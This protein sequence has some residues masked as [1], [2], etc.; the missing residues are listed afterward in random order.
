MGVT[1]DQNWVTPKFGG[2]GTEGLKL[3]KFFF[4]I[5]L[6]N[7]SKLYNIFKNQPPRLIRRGDI[8]ISPFFD[9]EKGYSSPISLPNLARKL[10]FGIHIW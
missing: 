2:G 7:N 4:S 9:L 6:I 8:K 5:H 1:L 10:K 3:H